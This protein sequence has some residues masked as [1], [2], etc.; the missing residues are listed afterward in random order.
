M[1]NPVNMSLYL[2]RILE[3]YTDCDH[4][5]KKEEIINLFQDEYGEDSIE[6]KRFHRKI[7]E[8]IEAGYPIH[9]TRGR[10]SNYY[11]EKTDLSSSELLFI[12][13]LIEAHPSISN[14]ETKRLITRLNEIVP[15]SI[16]VGDNHQRRLSF[17]R[18]NKDPIDG[19]Q[20][21][22]TIIRAMESA[23]NVRYKR[24]SKDQLGNY[25]FSAHLIMSPKTYQLRQGTFWVSGFDSQQRTFEERLED[26]FNVEIWKV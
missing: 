18:T 6:D 1:K 7:N 20:R 22:E 13:S 26:M 9:K 23:S 10:Y 24:G 5:L 3:D 17:L 21:F 2:L 14:G 8:L 11:Y 16:R 19:I 25:T 15:V 4:P 12:Y